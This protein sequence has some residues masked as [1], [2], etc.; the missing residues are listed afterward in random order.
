[1]AD[2]SYAPKVYNKVG[3]NELV[4]ASGGKITIET[5]GA[6]IL[7]TADP[8]IVGALWNSAGTIT[9]SAG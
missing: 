5:G 9:M 7:P 6:I 3:G 4:V 8:H 2:N 1:M